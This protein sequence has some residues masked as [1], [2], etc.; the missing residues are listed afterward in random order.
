MGRTSLSRPYLYKLT[1]EGRFPAL[2]KV[3]AATFWVEH[4]VESWIEAR[5]AESRR[6]SNAA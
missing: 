5:I 4:E 3:G 2:V 1:A 6:G